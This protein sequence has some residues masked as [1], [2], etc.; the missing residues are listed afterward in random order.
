MNILERLERK[1]KLVRVGPV[2]LVCPNC[3]FGGDQIITKP[4][5]AGEGTATC[6]EC[7]QSYRFTR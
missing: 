3:G 2:G 5:I 6:S 4:A 1:V 7:Q